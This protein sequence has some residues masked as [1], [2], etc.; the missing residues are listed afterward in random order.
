MTPHLSSLS[1]HAKRSL[2]ADEQSGHGPLLLGEQ[3]TFF[4]H[5]LPRT[6]RKTLYLKLGSKFR[7]FHYLSIYM[8][9]HTYLISLLILI[10]THRVRAWNQCSLVG[11]EHLALLSPENNP[12]LKGLVMYTKILVLLSFQLASSGQHTWQETS[13][14]LLTDVPTLVGWIE[15]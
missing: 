3:A 6:N 10:H 8:S 12:L 11:S 15:L 13:G 5:C 4:R 7:Q 2:E 9:S 1:R 14:H